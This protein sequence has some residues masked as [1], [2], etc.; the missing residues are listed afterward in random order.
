M[1][2]AHV[3]VPGFGQDHPQVPA[4]S[5]RA[6]TKTFGSTVAVDD[7]S[8]DVPQSAVTGFIGANGSGKTTT[9]RMIVGLTQADSGGARIIGRRYHEL[10]DPRSS[11]GVVLSRLGGHPGLTGRQHLR[12]VAVGA[13]VP[14]AAIDRVLGEVGLS[15]AADRRLG[16]YSTGMGQRLALAVALL[17][18][19]S[20]LI[21]DE[22]ASGL[23]P[24]GIRWLRDLL[25][26]RADSGTAV[27]LSTHQLSGLDSIL[28]HTVV[29]ESGRLVAEGTPASLIG[30][31]GE[32][33]LEDAVLALTN[34][35]D[36]QPTGSL[37]QGADR[38]V[39]R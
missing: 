34:R 25:R 13:G 30:A 15:D 12:F 3:G 29:I 11:V 21:L 2:A 23:D 28:D 35:S 20:V 39:S 6:L 38:L 5:V 16:T 7:L 36:H 27:F 22:P 17:A 4:I 8:F 26:R 18:D 14:G 37:R 33:S 19:P 32:A 10:A 31:S 1:T 24:R 9:M